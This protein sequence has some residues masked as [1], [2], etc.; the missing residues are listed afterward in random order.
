[1]P[2]I[3]L[4]VYPEISPQQ[5]QTL[6]TGITDAMEHIMH[7][8]REVTAVRVTASEG[9]WNI[10]GTRPDRPTAYLDIKITAGTNSRD[11]KA[12]LLRHLHRLLDRTLG[13]I[14]EASYVVIHELPAENWGYAGI[15]QQER[16]G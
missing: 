6:A 15:S 13:G 10:D 5:A 1:M 8:R 11:D 14:A 9:L 16:L 3:D 12:R 4:R 7:K 2:Y